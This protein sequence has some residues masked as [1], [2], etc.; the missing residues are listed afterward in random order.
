MLEAIVD[1]NPK[2]GIV[3]EKMEEEMEKKCIYC[4]HNTCQ[5]QHLGAP[6]PCGGLQGAASCLLQ[7]ETGRE[8]SGQA[9]ARGLQERVQGQKNTRFWPTPLMFKTKKE[10]KE[11]VAQHPKYYQWDVL[12]SVQWDIFFVCLNKN[13]EV[14]VVSQLPVVPVCATNHGN[15]H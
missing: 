9:H 3:R 12:L 6:G 10:T 11:W 7:E 5:A 8:F 15:A 13:Q 4:K 14:L 1:Y 2:K